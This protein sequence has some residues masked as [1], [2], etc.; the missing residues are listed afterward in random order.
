MVVDVCEVSEGR[1]WVCCVRRQGELEEGGLELL[2]FTVIHP[3]SEG[4]GQ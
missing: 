3:L 1:E 4:R 2:Q